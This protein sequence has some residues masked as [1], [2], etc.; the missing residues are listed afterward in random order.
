MIEGDKSMLAGCIEKMAAQSCGT[1][2]HRKDCAFI[3]PELL[4]RLFQPAP[5]PAGERPPQRRGAFLRMVFDEIAGAARRE[6]AK[7]KA[8]KENG[9][10]RRVE[11]ELEPL[12]A[13]GSIR[14]ER[15]A[16]ALGCGRQ[17]LYRRLKAEGLTFAQV[18][19]DLRRRQAVKLIRDPALSVK[20]VAYRLGFSDPAA[21]SRAFK[22]WTGKCPQAFRAQSG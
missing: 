12:L 4:G 16:R 13:T 5:Q 21:F 2:D 1:C 9:F 10:R 19:D 15:V 3:V 17:T 11:A 14:I 20:E 8:T 18:L 22:R 6:M 7:K